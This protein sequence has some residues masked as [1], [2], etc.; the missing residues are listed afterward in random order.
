MKSKI[1]NLFL[2]ITS[3]LGFLQWGKNQKL[4]LFQAEAE[5]ISKLFTDTISVIH[6]FT[7][8]PLTGQLL[9]LFT[10]FQNPPSKKLTYISIAA[11]GLLLGFM[12]IIGILSLNYKILLSVIPFWIT[13]ILTVK[14]HR[15]MKSS[16]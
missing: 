15:K 1:L 10:L 11:L 13:V 2:I 12:F 16:E 9:L 5:I 3:L 4:F 6:P 14:Q 8:L 7:L